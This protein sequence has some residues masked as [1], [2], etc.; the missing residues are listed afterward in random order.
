MM[1]Q[2][3]ESVVHLTRAQVEDLL[4]GPISGRRLTQDSPIL[5][6]VW[7]AYAPIVVEGNPLQPPK[8]EKRETEQLLL[9]PHFGSTPGEVAVRLR[10]LMGTEASPA[11]I[12]YNQTYV[13]AKLTFKQLVQH[14]LPMT[15]WWYDRVLLGLA[16]LG[17]SSVEVNLG[18]VLADMEDSLVADLTKYSEREGKAPQAI[19]TPPD[20]LWMIRLVGS[21]WWALESKEQGATVATPEEIIK[22]VISLCDGIKVTIPPKLSNEEIAT[23][24]PARD[25]NRPRLVYLINLNRP[26]RLAVTRST[27]AVK[28]DAARRLFAIDCSQIAWAIIDS[29]IDARHPAFLRTRD[30]KPV[31]SV[32]VDP[33]PEDPRS[34]GGYDPALKD[35]VLKNWAE[36]T[37]VKKTY[38]FTQ[39]RD[40][41]DPSNLTEDKEPVKSVLGRVRDNAARDAISE[42]LKDLRNRL[43]RGRSVDWKLL[44]RF[45]EIPH[46]DNYK[47]PFADHGTHVAGILG[48]DWPQRL[49]NGAPF[50]GV[51]PDIELYDLRVVNPQTGTDDDEFAVLAALQFVAYLNDQHDYYAIHG[52]NL[53]LSIRHQIANF[54]CGRTPV[55][56]ECDRLVSTGVVV[57]AAAGNDGYLR[58]STTDKGEQAG[59]HTVSITDPGNAE[60]VITVGSTHRFLP[61]TYGVSYFSSRGPTGDGRIKP[62]LVAPGEKIRSTL[63]G[64]ADTYA[65]K[66]MDGTSMA[67][68][69]VSGAAALLMARHS[70]FIGEPLRIKK[71]LCSSATDLGRERY[72]QGNGMLDILRAL[73]S[74]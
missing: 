60:S 14:V 26:S 36:H 72:F 8:E 21:I 19:A 22:A 40:L 65:L 69:H 57:V 16:Q 45:L 25:P 70:E 11:K 32:G 44:E 39:I 33:R 73:Q 34:M 46:D 5:P 17:K 59:Y 56:D 54:A 63:M 64:V 3:Q 29:G 9:T 7:L 27:I 20:L 58:F 68:P 18:S 15:A 61:H 12:A 48:G 62:D 53:S 67:A 51:C 13:A 28:A 74:V 4:F 10:E 38:D 6:D 24:G 66:E 47:P 31:K 30:F 2:N 1:F 37:R 50:Q 52:V 71:V 42:D 43:T 41:L 35:S 55:C 23:P 49:E